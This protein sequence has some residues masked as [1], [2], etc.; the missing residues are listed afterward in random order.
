MLPFRAASHFLIGLV[1]LHITLSDVSKKQISHKL[2]GDGWGFVLG[3]LPITDAYRG[4]SPTQQTGFSSVPQ[5][6]KWS[7]LFWNFDISE[8]DQWISK[9]G[10]LICYADDSGL[11]YEVTAGNRGGMIQGVNADLE[12]LRRIKHLLSV[13]NLKLMYTTF[14]RSTMECGSVAFMGAADSHLQKLD[15]VQDSAARCC[16]F[17]IESLQSRREAAAALALKLTDGVAHV[18]LQP[19]APKF[20][21]VMS[22]TKKRTRSATRGEDQD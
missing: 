8:M 21:K 13:E 1:A 17:E 20:G 19:F 9:L 5:G 16:G 22:L 15:R 14:V 3:D 18:K 10:E 2:A 6:G 7:P 12:S 11:W 4:H